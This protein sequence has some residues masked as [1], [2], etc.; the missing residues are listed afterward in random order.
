[1]TVYLLP[2]HLCRGLGFQIFLALAPEGSGHA[3]LRQIVAKAS[4]LIVFSHDLK[5][6]AID[7][8]SL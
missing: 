1:E 7:I 2:R 4:M 3:Q 8:F 5:V 6:V